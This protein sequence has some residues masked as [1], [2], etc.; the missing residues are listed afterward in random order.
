MLAGELTNLA[1]LAQGKPMGANLWATWCP[2]CRAERPVLAAAQKQE[3]VVRFVFV[4]Q[5]EDG[6]TARHYLATAG[7]VLANVV[8]DSGAVKF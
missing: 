7:L 8:I 4:D 3:S 1:A 6:A 5:G 2:P